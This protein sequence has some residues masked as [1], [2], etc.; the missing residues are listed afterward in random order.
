GEEVSGGVI[1]EGRKDA[2]FDCALETMPELRE[3]LSGTELN[4]RE[5]GAVTSSR[6]LRQVQRGNVAL[7]GDAS[8]SVDAITGEGLRLALLQALA[9]AESIEAGALDQYELAHR[10]LEKRPLLMARLMVWLRRLDLVRGRVLESF[11]RKPELLAKFLAFHIG[12]LTPA[13]LLTTG[14]AL[15]WQLLAA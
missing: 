2:E 12:H 15:G 9:L 4:G 11:A 14:A 7:L 8:G 6:S 5:R 1:G 13:E 10:A 3:R